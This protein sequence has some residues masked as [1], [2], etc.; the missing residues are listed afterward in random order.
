MNFNIYFYLSQTLISTIIIN[1]LAISADNH[2]P[3]KTET[4]VDIKKKIIELNEQPAVRAAVWILLVT[5]V[6]AILV[7]IFEARQNDQF[8]SF[9]DSVWWVLVTITTVG[10]GDK[11]PVTPIGKLIGIFVMFVG[12]ALLSVITAT[13]SSILVTRKI[14]EGKGLQ[15]I[16]LRDHILLCGWNRQAQDILSTFESGSLVDHPVVLINQLSEEEVD[17]V[18]AHYTKFPIKFVRGDFTKEAILKRA[19]VQQA[20]SAIIL[21]DDGLHSEKTGDE[22]TV[23]ATLSIKTLN[24]KIKVYAHIHDKENLSHLHKAKADEVLVSDA[25]SGY[26]LASYVASPGISQFMQNIFSSTSNHNIQRSLIPED[27][28]GKTYSELQSY[29]ADKCNGILLGLGE[30]TEP[31]SLTD[32]MS[33]D[34]SSYLDTFIMRKFQE[35]GRRIN[36]SEQVKISINPA[37]ETVLSKNSF[38]ISI[39]SKENEK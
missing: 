30:T 10:Y 11:V 21:P 24:P 7:A 18:I 23:L 15:E 6:A 19:N 4:K 14:K 31:F 28:I 9:W 29:Y 12:I 22:R 25:Y 8:T 37:E 34:S 16:K 39:E 27:L 35:A 13:L 1:K 36:S 5:L 17:E 26:L 38:Y 33:E 3:E 20:R 32:L 2:N